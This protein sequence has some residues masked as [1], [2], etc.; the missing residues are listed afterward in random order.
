[1]TVPQRI[2]VPETLDPVGMRDPTRADAPFRTGPAAAPLAGQDLF[3]LANEPERSREGRPVRAS[4][5]VRHAG[6]G[7]LLH[8]YAEGATTPSDVLSALRIAIDE[9]ESGRDA[10]LAGVPGAEAAA[11]DST[12]RW[13][14]GTARP[15][16]GIPFG[17]KDIID[18]AG[19]LV[20]SGSAFT[21]DRIAVDDAPVV[22]ALR[23]AGAIPFVMTATTEFA[24]GSPFNPRYG[25]VANPWDATRWTGGS[26]TGSGAALAARLLP[27]ALGTDTGGSIRVPSCWCGTT[28]LKPSRERVSRAG[29]APLSWTLDH[30]GPMARSAADI[31]ASFPFMTALR[32]VALNAACEGLLQGPADVA[33]LRIGVP[34]GWFTEQVSSGVLSNWRAALTVFETLGCQLVPMPQID[35][36]PLHEAGWTILLSELATFHEE[37]IDRAALFD[38]GLVHRLRQG[39]EIR[40]SDYGRALQMRLQAQETVAAAMAG[41]DLM[42]TPGLGGEAG[43]L[44]RMTVDV[45]GRPIPFQEIISRNT[46]LFDLTGFPALMLPSGLGQHGLPTGIQIV[47]RPMDDGLCLRAGVAFQAATDHHRALPPR[48]AMCA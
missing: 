45:D 20:T 31:A 4:V 34:G 25:A 46:M 15:L 13:Q 9:D 24:T 37:R 1:M 28:G 48:L 7:D 16:E 23:A 27:L 11:A 33:G 39:M 42:I 47:G 10:I 8:A 26:S 38:A 14:T 30:V 36:E 44:D 32:D 22:A 43:R 18:V 6:V 2:P 3:I 17:I 5:S 21:G 40:A 29:V 35:V 41:V 19:T 12:R